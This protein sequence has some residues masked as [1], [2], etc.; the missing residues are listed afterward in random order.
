MYA[1]NTLSCEVLWQGNAKYSRMC[2]TENV[3]VHSRDRAPIS[4]ANST[5]K[6]YSK[7]YF[8]KYQT[9]QK[10]TEVIFLL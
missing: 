3:T 5:K 7:K 8:R 2:D 9:E 6:N 10:K 1:P 4:A